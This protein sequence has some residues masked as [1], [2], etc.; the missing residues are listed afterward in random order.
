[1]IRRILP[2]SSLL[3]IYIFFI[4]LSPNKNNSNLQ[5]SVTDKKMLCNVKLSRQS[6]FLH[7]AHKF[8]VEN[9]LQQPG[10][11]EKTNKE[12]CIHS[13][14]LSRNVLLIHQVNILPLCLCKPFRNCVE[15]CFLN[16]RKRCFCNVY[17]NYAAAL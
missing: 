8:A 3:R 2:I 11:Q 17:I 9:T 14:A 10:K 12:R 4:K 7:C 15:T 13:I 6:L 1:M 5:N 16:N